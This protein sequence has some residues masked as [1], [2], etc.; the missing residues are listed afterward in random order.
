MAIQPP[1]G[2]GMVEDVCK[3]KEELMQEVQDLRR[4][5][6]TLS[7]DKARLGTDQREVQDCT[8]PQHC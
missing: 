3:S 5:L 7:H 8:A 4:Q 1:Y 2:G 6:A